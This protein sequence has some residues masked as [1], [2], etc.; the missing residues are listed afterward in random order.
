MNRRELLRSTLIFAVTAMCLTAVIYRFPAH[1]LDFLLPLYRI[2]LRWLISAFHI[3]NL[4]WRFDHGE[5][6]VALNV[7]LSHPIVV[8]DRLIPAG[9]SISAST[10][11]AHAW[12]YP[13][14]IIALVVSWPGIALKHRPGLVVL[15][16]PFMLIGV[17][18]DGPLMLWGAVED[19]LYWRID[20]VRVLESG[21][22]RAQHFLDGGGRY[23][24]AF[25]FALLTIML[26]RII[27]PEKTVSLASG[28]NSK[29]SLRHSSS[30]PRS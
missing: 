29:K 5:A 9:V 16:L 1:L 11:A 22:S 3:D 15:A 19:F 12:L 8:L 23:A 24:M 25:V 10:L 30:K 21:G 26:F 13:V 7:T 28:S 18:L 14:L 2:E 20:P 17:L 4:T 6:V 27:V